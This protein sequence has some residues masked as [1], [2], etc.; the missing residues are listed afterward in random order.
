MYT[1]SPWLAIWSPVEYLYTF[2]HLVQHPP[3][4]TVEYELRNSDSVAVV[5]AGVFSNYMT[6]PF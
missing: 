1:L 3:I 5:L 4:A 6:E 2:Y